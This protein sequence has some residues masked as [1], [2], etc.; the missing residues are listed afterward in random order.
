LRY[1]HFESARSTG[2]G[3]CTHTDPPAWTIDTS[4][5][6]QR[7]EYLRGHIGVPDSRRAETWEEVACDNRCRQFF[8]VFIFIFIFSSLNSYSFTVALSVPF[9][10]DNFAPSFSIVF[11]ASFDIVFGASVLLVFATWTR[12]MNNLNANRQHCC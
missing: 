5:C 10:F 9:C 3:Y 1:F 2:S 7:L 11:A 8:A 12:R 4:F 6:Y